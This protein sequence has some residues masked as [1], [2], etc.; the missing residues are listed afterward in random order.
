MKKPLEEYLN[1][2]Y[3]FEV[4]YEA[5][6]DS[7]NY[8]KYKILKDNEIT[9]IKMNDNKAYKLLEKITNLIN[10]PI[11]CISYDDYIGETVKIS[12]YKENKNVVIDIKVASEYLKIIT[13]NIQ[14]TKETIQKDLWIK[15]LFKTFLMKFVEKNNKPRNLWCL[16]SL[17][18]NDLELYNNVLNSNFLIL[19]FSLYLSL[20]QKELF[21]EYM[22]NKIK[23]NEDDYIHIKLIEDFNAI[24]EIYD[25]I[26]EE[27]KYQ[28]KLDKK[29][30]LKLKTI[31]L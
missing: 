29:K 13:V 17:Y 16:L 2:G 4:E 9:D 27:N 6:G 7:I 30:K 5:G 8:I 3:T 19:N 20:Y 11:H 1:E 26:I 14:I 21:E 31:K 12:T 10:K 28:I 18:N 25:N 22:K 24:I 23:V 15:E